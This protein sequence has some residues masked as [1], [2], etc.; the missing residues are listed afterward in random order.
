MNL[1]PRIIA[2]GLFVGYAPV[3][4][5]TVGSLLGLFL[6]WVVPESNTIFSLPWIGVLFLIG[7]WAAS[8]VEKQSGKDAPII[9]IDEIVGMLI[10]VLLIEKTLAGLAFGFLLFRLFDIVKL[11][12]AKQSERLPNGWGVM[13]DDVVAGIYSMAVLRMIFLFIK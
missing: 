11:F 5:G 1:F 10:T 6:Y 3:A 8:E 7:V 13:M 12:P 4:P 9:V 2:T